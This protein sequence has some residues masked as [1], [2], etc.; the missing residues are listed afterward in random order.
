MDIENQFQY[1]LGNLTT[2]THCDWELKLE[3]WSLKE[4][5]TIVI[6]SGD[7]TIGASLLDIH[8]VDDF[9][10]AWDLSHRGASVPQEHSPKPG[11]KK[12]FLFLKWDRKLQ[13]IHQESQNQI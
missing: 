11:R 12:D 6:A 5:S 10:V 3:R 13:N 4:G 9:G 1:F 2:H 7:Q 8:A